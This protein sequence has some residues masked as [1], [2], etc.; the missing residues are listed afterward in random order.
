[1]YELPYCLSQTLNPRLQ[2]TCR[3]LIHDQGYLLSSSIS[4]FKGKNSDSTSICAVVCQKNR[5]SAAKFKS[6]FSVPPLLHTVTPRTDGNA[7]QKWK[8]KNLE[9]ME[10]ASAYGTQNYV[11]NYRIAPGWLFCCPIQGQLGRDT[12][13]RSHS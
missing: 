12:S 6:F 7:K 2:V 9:N 4:F 11:W 8:A 3:L 5:F 10:T 13:R 1:M